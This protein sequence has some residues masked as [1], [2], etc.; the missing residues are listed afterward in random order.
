MAGQYVQEKRLMKIFLTVIFGQDGR[1]LTATLG[2][3]GQVVG[4][5]HGAMNLANPDAIYTMIRDIRP[6]LKSVRPPIPL[7]T[8]PGASRTGH[9]Y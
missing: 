9:G 1:E 7:L 2:S 5:D 4:F 3:L 6:D 8:R